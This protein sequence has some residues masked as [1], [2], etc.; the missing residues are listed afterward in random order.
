MPVKY[1][2][3]ITSLLQKIVDKV[4]E[5]YYASEESAENTETEETITIGKYGFEYSMKDVN[6]VEAE[7][8]PE[9]VKNAVN[10][11]E[12]YTSMMNEYYS[13]AYEG[14]VIE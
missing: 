11:E 3:D 6:L 5:E 8:L 9:D 2:F 10:F 1:S 7:E 12:Y 13:D 14:A 4:Y